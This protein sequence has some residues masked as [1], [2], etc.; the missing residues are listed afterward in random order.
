VSFANPA[1]LAF[2]AAVPAAVALLVWLDRRRV[3]RAE[4]WAR[5]AL[6]PNL[7]TP[8]P[9][10]RRWLPSALLLLGVTL[11][12]VGFARPRA[13]VTVGRNEATLVAVVDISG[14]MAAKDVVPT[15]LRAARRRIRDLLSQLP[16]SYR[17]A[18][19]AFSDHSA[20]IAPPTRDRSVV[21]GALAR[22]HTGPQGTALTEAVLRA[23]RL[24]AAL[25]PV[26]GKRP[27]A[28]VVVFSDGGENAGDVSPQQVVSAAQKAHVP[29]SSVVVGTPS[30][31]VTQRLQGGYTEEIAVPVQTQL[32]TALARGTGGHVYLL[33]DTLSPIAAHLKTRTG[34][35]RK[36]VEVT[37]GAAA[38]GLAL[39]LAGGLLSGVWFRRIP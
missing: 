5:P 39:M 29:V 6:L 34:R 31:I 25:P 3:R 28:T 11:L 22:L 10:W 7:V 2:L 21:L 24:A 35:E 23:I 8:P 18:A 12:L 14:S 4:R 19:V 27:P 13:R 1:L 33:A 36:T 20:V 32:L 17:V 15:R 38:G 16:T 37:A 26:D 30:G 9:A